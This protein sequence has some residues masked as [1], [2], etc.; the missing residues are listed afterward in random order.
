MKKVFI[1]GICGQDGSHLSE[2]LLEKGY[3]VHGLVR[4]SSSPNTERIDHIRN[5]IHLHYG[6][7]TDFGSL[8]NIFHDVRPDEVYNLAAQSHVRTSFENPTYTANVDALGTLRMLEAARNCGMPRFYQASTSELFGTT[9]VPQN[10]ESP[11]RPVSPYAIS[12]LYAYWTVVNYRES[13][14]MFAC[15]GIL[16]N[17]EG[18]RR[19]EEFVTQ[20]IVKAAVRIYKGLEQDL[21]LGNLNARRDWGYAPEFCNAMFLMLQQNKP[22]DYVI[23]TGESHTV[24]EFVQETFTYLGLDYLKYI[25][26]DSNL[27]RP[28]EVDY[29]LADASKAKRMLGWEPKVKFHQLV[30]IM[31]DAELKKYEDQEMAKGHRPGCS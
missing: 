25:R 16:F 22:D 31:V 19:P 10:E 2:L 24:R 7:V 8:M 15:N 5:K 6:D 29:L 27:Y 23:G 30:R 17:H 20:K 12:K 26:L 3:E 21:Y 14:G 28:T 9:Q 1:S 4:R 13:F 18:P 11:F